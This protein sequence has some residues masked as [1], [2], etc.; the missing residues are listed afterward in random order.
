[1]NKDTSVQFSSKLEMSDNKLWGAHVEVPA[2]VVKKLA[3][4]ASRRVV[5]RLN[6]AV[7]YQC[8]MLPHGNGTFVI[9]VNKSLRSKLRLEFG[10]AVRVQLIKDESEYGLP[11]PIELKELLKQ[12]KEG[13]KLLHALT[14]GKLRTLLYMIGK[15]KDPDQRIAQS[16]V[17][18][19]HLKSNGGKL[20]YRRLS[21]A[22]KLKNLK[23]PP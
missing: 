18:V 3:E 22:L 2:V 17:I 19:N 11:M 21:E 20:N 6:D 16:L 13:K 10:D 23:R 14:P 7:E 1:M 9:T 4:G 15:G 12:D 5:C 8:A